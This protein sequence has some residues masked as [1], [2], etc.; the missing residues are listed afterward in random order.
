M[1]RK[2]YDEFDLAGSERNV[3]EE[4]AGA[5]ATLASAENPDGTAYTMP[6]SGTVTA[7]PSGT[8]AVTI[9]DGGAA[10]IGLKADAAWA[11][12]DGTVVALLKAIHAQLVI[13][14]TNTEPA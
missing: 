2:A 8:Q 7:T 11:S 12:G 1:A 5:L 6:V 4:M 13:I 14:A 3:N 10:T 9:V